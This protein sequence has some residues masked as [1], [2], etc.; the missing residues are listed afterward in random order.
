MVNKIII[1]FSTN[2]GDAI[3]GLPVL[4]RLHSNYPQA[5]ISAITSP[6]THNFFLGNSLIDE[7][8][9]FDKSWKL[10]AKIRFCLYLR[11][12]YDLIA[13][14]K[15]SFLPVAL[16]I[17]KRTPF[18][19]RAPK[20]MHATN[21]YLQLIRKIAPKKESRKSDFILSEDEKNKWQSQN[22]E[23]S[24]FIACSSHSHLKQYPYEYLKEVVR[25]LKSSYNIVILGEERDRQFYKDILTQEKVTNLVG[26]TTIVEAFYLLKN[27]A[28]LLLCVDSGLMHMASYVNLPVVALFGPT[29]SI[30]YGPWSKRSVVLE[31][32]DLT[33]VPRVKPQ[34][35]I[36]AVKKV[37][38]NG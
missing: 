25:E 18:Y 22:L 6:R 21:I 24:V 33:P 38:A 13:D 28:Q 5:K 4:D 14:L 15:N 29:K 34:E 17:W 31:S 35:V 9:L 37:L 30:A 11:G 23:K 3:I 2:L 36:K 10:G 12:K 7:V 20:D 1:N 27:Y 8:I 26:K 19:R 16:G 32:K